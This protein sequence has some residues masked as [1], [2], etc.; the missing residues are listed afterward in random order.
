LY[1][2]STLILFASICCKKAFPT[3]NVYFHIPNFWPVSI[4]N[5]KALRAKC[6]Q[7]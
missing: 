6:R 1:F 5:T 2:S 7:I 4:Q 3:E